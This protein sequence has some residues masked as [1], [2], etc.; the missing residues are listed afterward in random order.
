MTTT[1]REYYND[2]YTTT[3][4]ANV[5]EHIRLNDSP[6]VV[7]D[8]TFFYPTSGGQPHDTGTLDEVRVVDVQ[9]RE[10]DGAVVHILD[11]VLDGAPPGSPVQGQVDWGR[12][13]DHMQHHT[14]QHILSQA[15][16]QVAKAE[17]VSFHLSPDSVTIDLNK[18]AL[19]PTDL[20]AAED[21]ANRIVT[22]NRTVRA[23]FVSDD[24]RTSLPLRKVPDVEGPFRVVVVDGFDWNA[25]G[26]THVART[27]EIGLIKVL[28]ADRRGDTLRIEFRCGGR[29]LLDYRSKHAVTSQLAASLTTGYTEVPASL[30]K[31]REE[32]KTLQRDLRAAR[33]L[34]IESEARS[35]WAE[36]DRSA[37]FA[38]IVHVFE[39]RDV[40]DVRQIAQ[41]LITQPAT[42]V[43]V[44]LAGEKVQVIAARSDDLPHDMVPVLRHALAALGIERGGGR[45]SFAQGGGAAATREAVQAALDAASTLILNYQRGE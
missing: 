8:H 20:D 19:E 12:R 1:Q 31:L 16:V 23:W 15:F 10:S 30:D 33:V 40:N 38:L 37:G 39:N 9:I 41:N 42:L 3:F 28:R 36:A 24:E 35:L 13:F 14:G 5:V 29:A 25:C 27:G 32:N 2:S 21:L 18:A 11:R 7:L 26:G 22:E 17:T 43:L 45:P 4:T 34:L 6:A 44:G